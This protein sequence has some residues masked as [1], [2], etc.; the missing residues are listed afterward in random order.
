MHC[1]FGRQL[2]RNKI[3][4]QLTGNRISE[5]LKIQIFPLEGNDL[6]SFPERALLFHDT[7]PVTLH[8][9]PATT[10][11]NEN[12]VHCTKSYVSLLFLYIFSSVECTPIHVILDYF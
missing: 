12:P 3:L 11:L 9:S 10:I 1:L 5:G 8:Y 4:C 6:R 7:S 2:E